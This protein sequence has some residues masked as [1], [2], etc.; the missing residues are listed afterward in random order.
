MPSTKLVDLDE[1]R[2]Q[3]R[4][5]AQVG[6]TLAEIVDGNLEAAAAIVLQS[7]VDARQIGHLLVFRQFQH[8]AVGRQAQ[9]LQQRL[10][11][12]VH[13]LRVEQAARRDVE[14]QPADQA[15]PGK[16]AQ[17]RCPAGAFQLQPQA[18]RLGRGE[19]AV[20]QVQRAVARTAKISAS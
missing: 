14:E 13:Q 8:Q 19:Q 1:L 17:A 3:F 2:T 20:R 7:F 18:G 9:F 15:E 4:P 10:G 16:A 11:L 6:K 5:H 12:P